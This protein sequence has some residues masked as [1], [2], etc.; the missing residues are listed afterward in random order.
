MPLGMDMLPSYRGN[1]F[2]MTNA[3]RSLSA[4]DFSLSLDSITELLPKNLLLHSIPTKNV[5]FLQFTTRQAPSIASC[6][7]IHYI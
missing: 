2:D 6:G 7:K 3:L 5:I 4:S 1:F